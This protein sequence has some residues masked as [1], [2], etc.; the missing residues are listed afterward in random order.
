MVLSYFRF[1]PAIDRTVVSA[2][3][4]VT[5]NNNDDNRHLCAMKIS[6]DLWACCSRKKQICGRLPQPQRVQAMQLGLKAVQML[7]LSFYRWLQFSSSCTGVAVSRYHCHGHRRAG[8]PPSLPYFAPLL[9]LDWKDTLLG[10]WWKSYAPCSCV[11]SPIYWVSTMAELGRFSE[12]NRSWAHGGT[13]E[14]MVEGR[15]RPWA[16]GSPLCLVLS[17][18]TPSRTE[19]LCFPCTTA[20]NKK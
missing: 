11:H 17:C 13:L 4:G 19:G 18:A 3:T 2:V 1:Y 5:Y 15:L 12:G 20:P 6:S 10:R 9:C 16:A 7:C 8:Q 14:C